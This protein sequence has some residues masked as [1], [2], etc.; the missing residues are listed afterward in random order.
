MCS[1]GIDSITI[2]PDGT[3][4]PCRRLPMP[5]GNLHHESLFKIW[6]TS[7]LLWEIRNKNNLKGKCNNCEL[8][9]RCSGC[10]AIA[11]ALTGD[12]LAEDPQ[13]WK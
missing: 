12:Y 10:R 13:C 8:I 9:P 5:I 6:Y 4:F 7:D 2:M 3:V 1:I 11:Y